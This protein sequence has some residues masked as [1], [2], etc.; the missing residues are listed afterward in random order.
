MIALDHIIIAAS[1]LEEGAAWVAKTLGVRTQAGGQHVRMGTHNR[2]LNLD[3]GTYLEIIA[4]D[5]EG[6]QP[7]QP[8]WFALD[9][10]AMQ[11]RLAQ[12][13]ALI[14]W[15][16]HTDDIERDAAQ[17]PVALGTIHPME[18]GDLRWR[19]TIPTDGHLPGDGLVPTLIQWDVDDHPSRR[20]PDSEC[21]LI[22]LRGW[23]PR[24]DSL[25]L[26]DGIWKIPPCVEIG[27]LENGSQAVLEMAIS[28]P[29]G[30]KIIAG[31]PGAKAHL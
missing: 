24:Y 2:L 25:H 3:G 26:A 8:R 21:R 6:E 22:S 14:H 30:L 15:V 23:H 11:A 10:S 9:S 12:G 20:L 7:A 4:I 28:A 19:I 18:R 31:G 13:P 1:T 29:T 27:P 17:S 5:P 16:A